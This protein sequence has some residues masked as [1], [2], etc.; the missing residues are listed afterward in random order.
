MRLLLPLQTQP[1]D[2]SSS[3]GGG[4]WGSLDATVDNTW[5]T[6]LLDGSVGAVLGAIVALSVLIVTVRTQN[7]GIQLQLTAQKNSVAEQLKAQEKS[8]HL[9][10]EAQEKSVA[11]QLRVQRRENARVREVTTVSRMLV[12]LGKLEDEREMLTIPIEQRANDIRARVTDLIVGL[13]E[14]RINGTE[15]MDPVIGSFKP[16]V[17]CLHGASIDCLLDEDRTFEN[18]GKTA[19][20]LGL[21]LIAQ[22]SR[23]AR[24]EDEG[25]IALGEFLRTS[26][27]DLRRRGDEAWMSKYVDNDAGLT[28][29]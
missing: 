22:L 8:L 7:D 5:W 16:F 19:Y 25:R 29:A 3:G 6:V 10:L 13:E 17:S 14:L 18:P 4:L 27:S 21:F 12:T 23:Y 2:D 1:I 26:E 9:Q 24:S 20:H 11:E 15:S 28:I